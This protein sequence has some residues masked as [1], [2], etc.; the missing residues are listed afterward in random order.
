RG[1]GNGSVEDY[2]LYIKA[3]SY[4]PINSMALPTGEISPVDGTPFDF[5]RPHA[6]GQLISEDNEQLHNGRGYDHNWCIDKETEGVEL[7]CRVTDP[8]SGRFVEVLSDQPGLQLYSGNFFDGSE[9]GSNGKVL[10]FRSSFVLE[11]Q[12]YPDALNHDNFTPILLAPGESYTQSTIYRFG[13][14]PEWAPQGNHIRTSWA[15]SVSPENVHPEYPRP[16]LIRPSWQSLNGLWDYAIAP[17]NLDRPSF[18]DGKILVPFCAESSLSGVGKR[19]GPESALWYR[20]DFI[21]PDGWKDRVLLHFDAVDWKSEVW[22]NGERLGEHTGGYT[23]FEYDITDLIS[24]GRQELVLKVWDGTDNDEQPHGKQVSNPGGIWYTPVTGIWQ[25]VWIEPVGKTY[26]K[27]YNCTGSTAGAI[28]ITADVE[29][30]ADM[31]SVTLYE[32]GEGWDAEKGRRGKKIASASAL[33]GQ[34]IVLEVPDAKLWSPEHPYLY[35]LTIEAVS[36]GKVTDKVKAYTAIRS[37]TEVI[38][39]NGHKRLGLNGEP[40]FQY[41]PLDQGW[42]PDGLYTA[43][44]DEALAYDVIKTK[45][46]GYNFIRKHI[47]VEPAR[48][49]YHCDRLGMMVWQDMPSMAGNVD[50]FKND[51]IYDPQWG[52]K[53]YDTGWDYPLSETA[54]ATYYKEWG[55]IMA[56]LKKFPCIVVWVPFN[57]A[58]GQFDTEAVTDFT[59][60]QDPTRLVNSASGGNYRHCG[61]ILDSHNYPKPKMLLRSDG[62]QIDV[63]GEYGG[64]GYAVTGHTWQD[65]GNWGYKGKCESGEQVL[66]KYRNYA[67]EYLIP[68]IA[69]GV[70]A[71]VYTQTTDVEVE[72]NGLMT[73]DRKIIKVDEEELRRV[74]LQVIESLDD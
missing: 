59:R 6:I 60:E 15:D 37:C 33:P 3:S 58:W 36:G 38:D 5:R 35:A 7:L 1:Q 16:Q 40:Y 54:K 12:K 11:A 29:G 44:T 41:G 39:R 51:G 21:V 32:G 52:R 53:A 67:N 30:D 71:A 63:V 55:E 72:V 20:T 18:F 17:V 43:P 28:S 8:V 61:D 46:F 24:D 19:V 34:E 57:E 49:Y 65:E 23:A 56:Q 31:V 26:I 9:K 66:E 47:K 50:V 64:I 68:G 4:T 22:L 74:N 70:S 13:V 2:E 45:D 62:Q 10:G 42:W 25:S 69:D 73:Y 14:K 48:W 27:D